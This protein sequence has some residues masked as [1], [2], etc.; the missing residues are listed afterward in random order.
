MVRVV[1]PTLSAEKRR[2]TAPRLHLSRGLLHRAVRDRRAV[3][4]VGE[5]VVAASSLPPPLT[6]QGRIRAVPAGEPSGK[7]LSSGGRR[8]YS[9]IRTCWCGVGAARVRRPPRGAPTGTMPGG[10]AAPSGRKTSSR[11]CVRTVKRRDAKL[12]HSSRSE[13]AERGRLSGTTV[14]LR[15]TRSPVHD[16]QSRGR[17]FES[18][19]ARHSKQRLRARHSAAPFVLSQFCPTLRGELPSKV[20]REAATVAAVAVCQVAYL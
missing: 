2:G 9:G 7:C 18:R 20:P 4:C 12:T 1:S 19:Q 15:I 13:P 17:G 8:L 3:T 6:Y 11:R 14:S 5:R 16:C 10:W